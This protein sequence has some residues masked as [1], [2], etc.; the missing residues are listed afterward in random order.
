[1]LDQKRWLALAAFGTAGVVIAGGLYVGLKHGPSRNLARVSDSRTLPAPVTA[2]AA[3]MARGPASAAPGGKHEPGALLP[4]DL[5]KIKAAGWKLVEGVTPP[6]PKLVSL[7]VG[8]HLA[9]R[10]KEV[11]VQLA[12]VAH[13][14]AELDNARLIAVRAP[15]AETR[16]LAI[17]AIGRSPD[18]KSQAVLRD[19]YQDLRDPSDRERVLTYVRPDKIGDAGS[20]FCFGVMGDAGATDA[21]RTRV[22]MAVIA[23]SIRENGRAPDQLDPALLSRVP[24]EWKSQFQAIYT[25]Y[26]TGKPAS[27]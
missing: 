17:E 27:N 14:G 20:D 22:T 19:L 24:S 12:S 8:D 13:V 25:A 15:S 9:E 1:M 18:P 5:D 2:P 26:R 4:A 10:E 6:D 21:S 23:A 16:N 7:D 3:S 11:Q